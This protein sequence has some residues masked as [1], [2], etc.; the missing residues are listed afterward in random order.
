VK[1]INPGP[2]NW[3]PSYHYSSFGI[4]FALLVLVIGVYFFAKDMGW[5]E[6]EISIWPIILIVLGVYWIIKAVIV[7]ML[8]MKKL[9]GK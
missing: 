8:I 5:I 6:P 3:N 1:H 2:K 9:K 4:G 7:R